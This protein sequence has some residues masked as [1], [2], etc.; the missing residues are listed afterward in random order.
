MTTSFFS[1]LFVFASLTLKYK[2][3]ILK[4]RNSKE[5]RN[6]KEG[7]AYNDSSKKN[8]GA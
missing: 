4:V 7:N 3:F 2:Y 8:K 1:N 6:K 5:I